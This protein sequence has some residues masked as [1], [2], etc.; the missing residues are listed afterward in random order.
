MAGTVLLALLKWDPQVRGFLIV[1]TAF[2]ILVGSV[3]LLLATNLGARLGFL[4]A[5]AAFAGWCAVMG[6]IWVFYGIG[7]KGEAPHWD[8]K[9]V[10]TGELA[11]NSGLEETA[12]F[13]NGW[14]KLETGNPILG[15]AT[16]A[17]DKVLVPAEEEGEHG[18]GGAEA[19]S[20]FNPVFEEADDYTLVGGYRA[21]GEDYFIPG[22]YLERSETPFRGWLHQTH[23]ALVQVAPVIEE[24]DIGGPPAEPTADPTK[25]VTTV[26]MVRDLGKLRQP[27]ALFA[28][29][30][31]VAFAVLCAA[32]HRRDKEIMAA[33]AASTATA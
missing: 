32:L 15:D 3:Y 12:N 4:A 22:G 14:Q 29:A 24:Q 16:A 5:G 17:A 11:A 9:E 28:F 2:L 30:F 31:S 19:E 20:H 8:V 33:R 26:V 6:W 1:L 7:I 21:G 13:P 23:Y 27:S 25:P 18:G 10:I